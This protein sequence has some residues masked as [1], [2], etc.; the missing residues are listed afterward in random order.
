MKD[1][2]RFSFRERKRE[3][4][5]FPCARALSLPCENYCS[6]AALKNQLRI[7]IILP[8]Y[9]SFFEVFKKT[10]VLT[11]VKPRAFYTREML[12]F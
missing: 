5:L 11:K 4:Q 6:T 7:L 12:V 8:F 1:F 3:L 10:T 9:Y 2:Q